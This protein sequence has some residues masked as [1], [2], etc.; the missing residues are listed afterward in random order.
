[1]LASQP[2]YTDGG[3]VESSVLEL[4]VSNLGSSTVKSTIMVPPLPQGTV[5]E[6]IGP[7][8]CP[9]C[10][11]IFGA[12]GSVFAVNVALTTAIPGAVAGHNN[13]IDFNVNTSA[14]AWEVAGDYTGNPVYSSGTVYTTNVSP[15]Q[16][17]ARSE[18]DGSLQWSWVPPGTNAAPFTEAF[19]YIPLL[20]TNDLLFV[21]TNLAVYAIEPSTRA[22][23]WSYPSPGRMAISANGILYIATTDMDGQSDGRIVAINLH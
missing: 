23:V 16:L 13:L 4:I 11:P 20:L 10:A 17:E 2:Y 22:V 1:L 12:P 8:G 3:M 15:I 9:Y 7:Q 14:I 21:S 19:I 5:Q 18:T 6:T